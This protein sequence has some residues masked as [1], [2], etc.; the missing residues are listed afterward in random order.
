M[1]YENSYRVR[2]TG[3]VF[4]ASAQIRFT[5]QDELAVLLESA[6]LVAEKWL[7]DWHG[8]PYHPAAKDIIPIGRLA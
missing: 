3:K 7:G 5:S 4:S 1:L 2:N 6:G 8:N